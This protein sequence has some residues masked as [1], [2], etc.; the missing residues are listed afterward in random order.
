MSKPRLLILIVAYNAENN[1]GAV[2]ARVP[3]ALSRGI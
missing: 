1:I 3:P 2:L